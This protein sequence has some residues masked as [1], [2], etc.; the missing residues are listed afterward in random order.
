MRWGVFITTTLSAV[1]DL[2]YLLFGVI[3]CITKK[4]KILSCNLRM[5]PLNVALSIACTFIGVLQQDILIPL[6]GVNILLLIVSATI[7]L[8]LNS[9]LDPSCFDLNLGI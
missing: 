2:L 7:L 1:S 5:I 6:Y 3:G 4:D 8:Y 9:L